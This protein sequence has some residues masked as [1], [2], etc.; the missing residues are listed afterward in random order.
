MAEASGRS[1]RKALQPARS[2]FKPLLEM[3]SGCHALTEMSNWAFST[4]W[5]GVVTGPLRM[6][7][8]G[9]D[10]VTAQSRFE[11]DDS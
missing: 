5:A 9:L 10:E 1:F 2:N 4:P 11:G 7:L 8:S 6:G 3:T